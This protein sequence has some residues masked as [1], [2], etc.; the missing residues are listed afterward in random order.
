VRKATGVNESGDFT[1]QADAYARARPGYPPPIVERLC[2]RVGVAP[3]DPV[4]E[5]GAGT[6]LFTALLAERHLRVTA[7][8]PNAAMR[9]HAAAIPDVTWLDGTFEA[10]GLDTGSQRWVVAAQAFHWADPPRALPEIRRILAPRGWLTVLWNDRE[11]AASRVLARTRELVEA[12]VP[13]FDEGYRARDWAAVLTSGGWFSEVE[14]VEIAHEVPMTRERY[15]DLWRSH[16]LLTASAGREGVEA[17]LAALAPEL[18][19]SFPV[20]YRCR[21]WSARLTPRPR[22]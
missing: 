7:I 14:L 10:T 18:P 20:P 12:L 3:G 6:G 21:A 9:D 22:G 2:A 1:Q 11:V 15:L 19:A 13:G 17:L 8:E 16:H 5:I 4:A